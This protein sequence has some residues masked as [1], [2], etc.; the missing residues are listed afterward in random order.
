MES[1]MINKITVLIS[2][3]ALFVNIGCGNSGINA[4]NTENTDIAQSLPLLKTNK[5]VAVFIGS[6]VQDEAIDDLTNAFDEAVNAGMNGG[7]LRLSWD[8]LEPLPGSYDLEDMIEVLEDFN[9]RG[10]STYVNLGTIDIGFLEIPEEFENPENGDELAPGLNFNDPEI[11]SRFRALLE[12]IVPIMIDN[13]VFYL[14]IGNEVNAWLENNPDQ[15]DPYIDFLKAAKATVRSIDERLAVGT[16]Q[17]FAQEDEVVDRLIE[18]SDA[19][20][21]NYYPVD[22][23]TFFVKSPSV[24][25][26]EINNYVDRAAGKLVL[27]Q[28]MGCPSGYLPAPANSSSLEIQ[29]KCFENAFNT[30][31][32]NPD[33]RFV[34]VFNF[35]D[36][37]D[38]FCDSLISDFG[39]DGLEFPQD[40]AERFVE[41]TCTLGLRLNDDVLTE[42]PAWEVFIGNLE[43][44]N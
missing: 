22:I 24:I 4:E 42:K 1:L 43:K 38:A 12:E 32:S 23:N 44:L 20:V 7:D 21:F 41:W 30:F 40:A 37:D 18:V 16:T 15:V 14:S 39:L 26:S 36:F 33:L 5:A 8:E 10:F 6:L 17:I 28:E 31:F 3:I 13:G 11:I 19:V 9:S 35:I 29:G 25:E 34:S 2:I 27:F